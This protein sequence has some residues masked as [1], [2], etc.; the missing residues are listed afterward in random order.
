MYFVTTLRVLDDCVI[1]DCRTICMSNSYGYCY[2]G[3][4][5]NAVDMFEDGYYNYAVI[6]FVEEGFYPS[7][8]EQSWFKYEKGKVELLPIY[9]RPE[10]IGDYQIYIIG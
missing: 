10:E 1:D 7:Q 4:M 9:R 2:N 5:K 6:T 3:V 8:A